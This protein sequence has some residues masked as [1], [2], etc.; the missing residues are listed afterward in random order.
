MPTDPERRAE[1]M[2]AYRSLM[3]RRPPK[4][5]PPTR[6]YGLLI[7]WNRLTHFGA[8][9]MRGRNPNFVLDPSSESQCDAAAAISF[10]TL[11]RLCLVALR[12]LYLTTWVLQEVNTKDGIGFVLA[13]ADNGSKEMEEAVAKTTPATLK[14][15]IKFLGIDETTKPAWYRVAK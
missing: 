13:L 1:A 5:P 9:Y 2:E 8:L 6:V 12:D 4:S 14:A 3:S 7:P 15:L 11:P 10:N